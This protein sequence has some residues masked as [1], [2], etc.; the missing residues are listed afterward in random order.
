MIDNRTAA[1][2][3]KSYYSISGKVEPLPGEID[4][5]F[6]ISDK[7]NSYIL[8][9]SGSAAEPTLIDF[10]ISLLLHLEGKL[11]HLPKIVKD[12]H[13]RNSFDFDVNGEKY[14][15]RML[16][17]IDGILW[18]DLKHKTPFYY[19]SLGEILGNL[20]RNLIDFKHTFGSRPFSWDLDQAEW[21]QPYIEIHNDKKKW[22]IEKCYYHYQKV[23]PLL[24]AFRK[25]IIHNDAN[26][27][28]IICNE[29][30][31][32]SIIDFG[33]AIFTS[34]INDVAIAITYGVLECS[35]PLM[36]AGYIVKGYH[37]SFPLL[38]DEVEVLYELVCTRLLISLT[39]SAVNS[40]ENPDIE[41]H[42]ISAK[43]AWKLAEKWLEINPEYARAVFRSSC[44]FPPFPQSK[45]IVEYLKDNRIPISSFLVGKDPLKPCYIPLHLGSDLL[46]LPEDYN[47]PQKLYRVIQ[48]YLE[49]KGSNMAYGGYL[50]RRAFYITDEYRRMGIEGFKQRTVHLGED[51]WLETGTKILAPLDGIIKVVWDN[52][53][54]KDYGPL[55]ILEHFTDKGLKFYTLYGH[56]EKECLDR[57]KKGDPVTKGEL[58]AYIGN[59]EE[60]GGWAPHLHFQIII[61]LLENS[62]NFPGVA[63][64][65]EL[66]VWGELCP[67]PKFLI[68][69][70]GYER[71]EWQL[72]EQNLLEKRNRFL[73][74][75]L[76]LSYKN[77]LTIVRG[78]MQYL[79][80][81]NGQRYT[82]FV[83]N[84]AHV[85]HE[86]PA[87]VRAIQKQAAIL[88]TNT[89]YLHPAILH[90][91]ENLLSF[92]PEEYTHV[93]FVNSGSEANELALRIAETITGNRNVLALEM[94]YHGHT[95]T[96]IDVSSYKFER[97][98]G[99]GLPEHTHLVK[100]QSSMNRTKIEEVYLLHQDFLEEWEKNFGDLKKTNTVP[101][102]FIHE[103]ILSCGGQVLLPSEHFRSVYQSIEQ[104]DGIT[105]AD[106]VQT[107]FGRV[108]SSFWAFEL[109]GLLPGIVTLGKPIANGHPM[110][111]VV[112]KKW[113]SDRFTE[114]GMEFFST[115]GGNPVSC[116]AGQAVLQVVKES[117]L[118]KHALQ[119]GQY[120]MEGLIQL[121]NQ[122]DVIADV[123]GRGLFAGIE[124]RLNN[125]PASEIAEKIVQKLRQHKILLSTDGPYENV[126]KIKPPMCIEKFDI[127]QL[128]E[129]MD[130]ALNDVQLFI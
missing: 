40:I 80:D 124:F 75:A 93:Y 9:C 18:S 60:N 52:D 62:E 16:S 38:E 10:Q 111:A 82:D 98:G 67:D 64:P 95:R 130:N 39:M 42:Q 23:A 105:I 46:G 35:D 24:P 126:I 106:E 77:P 15:I 125:L 65:D 113:I 112:C 29:Q 22:L 33:D 107:G 110:G 27:N 87:V 11:D 73:S 104:V 61:H 114:K 97:K 83:N 76:S 70:P 79:M 43:S 30:G 58:L 102:T 63:F 28:N 25:S 14:T 89:R 88:N 41:Y 101:G 21:V 121:K 4:L 19:I 117:E 92:F 26:E 127:D 50:E 116:A 115:F 48:E 109:H 68:D 36:A 2:I 119:N 86:H 96:C 20:T 7:Q 13:H 6:K 120:L 91:A 31:V 85:G 32:I 94:G 55:I 72:E 103:S 71:N 129:S 45:A 1:K 51:Y 44:H 128:L 47:H 66:T 69:L 53:Y 5:N 84:V 37:S 108:G 99:L 56:L 12:V 54:Y 34:I 3:A 57:W 90:Y 8:K 81:N 123:R 49:S 74:K 78:Q 122:Y 17:W 118:Q 59:E 100:W